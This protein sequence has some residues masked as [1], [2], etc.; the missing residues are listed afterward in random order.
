MPNAR[1]QCRCQAPQPRSGAP[2]GAG[3]DSG[4]PDA[5][6][7][8]LPSIVLPCS[9]PPQ[10]ILYRGR[11]THGASAPVSNLHQLDGRDL[12]FAVDDEGIDSSISFAEPSLAHQSQ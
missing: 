1:P 5:A 8:A 4:T 10:M 12:V 9:A 3:L 6:Q 7:S 11:R 2:L